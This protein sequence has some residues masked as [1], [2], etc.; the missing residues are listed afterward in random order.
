MMAMNEAHARIK[1]RVWQEIAQTNL[2]VS[3]IDKETLNALVDLATESALLEVDEMIEESNKDTADSDDGDEEVLWKGR[4]FLSVTTYYTITSE[5][6][7]IRSGL[8]GKAYEY[9]ELIR[10]QDIDFDQSFGDRLLKLGDIT[11]RSHDTSHP[12]VTLENVQDPHGVYEILR[13]ALKQARKDNNFSY[14][15]EM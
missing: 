3:G 6:I 12:E 4:P 2:D 5:R 10:V 1:A 8:L 9:I 7:K 13:K 11:I 14:R 15:E